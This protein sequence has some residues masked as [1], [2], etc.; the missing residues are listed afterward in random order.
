MTIPSKQTELSDLDFLRAFDLGKRAFRKMG[1]AIEKGD[2]PAT[3]KKLVNYFK[4]RRR[5]RWFFDFRD[6]GR[7]AVPKLWPVEFKPDLPL[8]CMK[9]DQLLKNRFILGYG[10]ELDFGPKLKWFTNQ[11]R[12]LGVPGNVFRRGDF[13]NTLAIAHA[14]SRRAEYAIK[15]AELAD[16][17]QRDWPFEVDDQFRPGDLVMSREY[18]YKSMPTGCRLSNWLNCL[19]S[20]ILFAQ[21][22][23]VETAFQFIKTIWFTGLQFR[24]YEKAPYKPGNIHTKHCG[25]TPSIIAMMFPECRAM[26]PLMDLARRNF[27]LHVENNL[28]SDG[29]YQEWSTSYMKVTLEMFLLPLWLARENRVTLLSRFDQNRL[30]RCCEQ[31]AHLILPQGSPLDVGDGLTRRESTA[32]F[33]ALTAKFFRSRI[34]A[35]PVNRFR[36]RGFLP[37]ELKPPLESP[38]ISLPLVVHYPAS[39]YFVARSG[40]GHKASALAVVVPQR[41]ESVPQ[42]RSRGCPFSATGRSGRTYGRH[43]GEHSLHSCERRRNPGSTVTRLYLFDGIP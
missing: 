3:K 24:R 41:R 2:L 26:K 35:E 25:T 14:H 19:Y 15:F 20:G 5:P 43:S 30:R 37:P 29:G 10:I 11:T 9:A 16:R 4:Y 38:S 22:V 17:W 28:L 21:Q 12:D 39:G 32:S 40:P 7:G 31:F 27:A 42:P 36:L 34:L 1:K 13:F 6:G 8:E 18:G 23:P 33:L